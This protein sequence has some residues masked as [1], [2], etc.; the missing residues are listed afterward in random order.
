MPLDTA[1][2]PDPQAIAADPA[3]SAFVTANAGSGKTKTLVDRVARLLLR[4][5]A[6]D[7]ILCVTYTKA[8][9]AEMQRRLFGRLGGWA[10]MGD[11]ALRGELARLGEPGSQPRQ[12]RTLFARALETPGGLKIQT[13]H[14]F[15]EKLLRRFPLE[16]GVSPTFEVAEDAVQ[17]ALSA[18]ARAV[19]ARLAARP[20][21]PV[22]EAYAHFAAELAHT[23]FDELLTGL[24][25]RRRAIRGTLDEAGWEAA[26][27]RRCGFD[28][29]QPADPGTIRA[30][31]VL[32]P[33]L[34]PRVYRGA[35]DTLRR[36]GSFLACAADL[37]AVAAHA[38]AGH[39]D[40]FAAV[41]VFC[42]QQGGV[43]NW[44]ETAAAI[45]REPLLQQ[46][47]QRERDRVFAAR[48]RACAATVARDTAYALVLGRAYGEAYESL[49][50]SRNL[51]DFGDLVARTC[52][53][54]TKRADAAWVLY[55]LDGGVEHVL[56]DEAQDSAP[57]PWAIVQG[58][59]GEFF[60][61]AG[62]PRRN[63]DGPEP[64]VFAVG[65]EKQSIYSFQ[66]ARPEQLRR[67]LLRYDGLVRGA[68]REFEGVALDTS[69]RS[70]PEVLAFVDAVFALPG[71]RDAA[72]PPEGQNVLSHHAFRED[73]G[74]VDLWPW[75]EDSKTEESPAWDA[76]LD[77]DPPESARKRLARRIAL[78]IREAVARGD[79]VRTES[80]VRPCGYGDFLVLVRRR[81]VL[82]EEIIRALKAENVP[83]G[84]ADRLKLAEHILFDDLKA[85]ARVCLHPGD[86]LTLAALLRSPFF[87]L[88]EDALYRL[89]RGRP[90][91]LWASLRAAAERGEPACVEAWMVLSGLRDGAGS[92]Q[93]YEFY[94]RFLN[95][96]D[97]EG[98]SMG[99]RL[100]GRLGREA[101]DALDAFLG[102]AIA[103]EARGVHGLEAFAAALE[104]TALEIKRE[105][106]EGRGEVR[107]MTVHGAKGLE[108]PVVILPDTTV[109]PRAQGPAL[110]DDEAVGFLYAPRKGDD[111]PASTEA[112]KAR[113]LRTDHEG[114][115]LL[116]VALTRARDRLIICGRKRADRQA[117]DPGSWYDLCEQAFS[118]PELAGGVRALEGADGRA[119]RRFGPDPVPARQESEA[120]AD[121]PGLPD[122]ARRP[123]PHELAGAAY[124]SPSQIAAR[125]KAAAPSP[126]AAT[127]G[128]DRFRRGDLIHK[129]LEVLP[130]LPAADRSGAAAALLGKQRDLTDDQRAEMAAAAL[131]LLEDPRFAEVFGPGSRAE[132]AVAGTAP[133]L[134]AGL[135]VSGRVDRMVVTPERVLV[136]DFKTNRPSPDRAEDADPAYLQQMAVYVAVLRAV[137]P[138]RAVEAALVW[139]DGPKLTPLSPELVDRTLAAMRTA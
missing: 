4:G 1:A 49:K 61:G 93:P 32:P 123:A 51:L 53:L 78:T 75:D 71:A 120:A 121:A 72:P 6:P 83:V 109:K 110:L 77:G 89:A 80:A 59:A 90:G 58:L 128:I 112:R 94:A 50:A 42:T 117:V 108:A 41:D 17:A 105:Q 127:R 122:W 34:D 68:G 91:S 25:G 31:A 88:D 8:A 7:A 106:D 11:E 70:T 132:L 100:R 9:A 64:T 96:T 44:P 66:G 62:A 63:R 82:F 2:V 3:L 30:E 52:E 87:D 126:L 101:E 16:A 47:I 136:V 21:H 97:G 35:A 18:D 124:A 56:V 13:I 60:S 79:A 45:K 74:C 131:G 81:D 135:R 137:F 33:A 99:S 134:P 43:A 22:A 104:R 37:E 38:E 39:A 73:H 138:E 129:L 69:F 10:V 48:E 84:G 14:A 102:E 55:K 20:D 119:I 76:P 98:R 116:Y 85:L 92:A 36:S 111:C 118:A 113:D 46:R 139:T 133:D 40:F 103:A 12:A 27:W 19:L 54:L 15:C 5:A 115:R 26:L 107:V 65:D 28:D 23:H 125:A 114:L 95:R 130:E 24:E 86:D 57:V 29:G 67:E